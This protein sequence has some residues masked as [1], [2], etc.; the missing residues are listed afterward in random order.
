MYTHSSNP[1]VT[2]LTRLKKEL[3]KYADKKKALILERFF[4]TGP[5]E[6]GEGDLF[7]GV[8]VP[9]IRAVAK[10]YL[11][12][13]RKEIA[14]LLGSSIHEERLLALLILV[15]QFERAD[16]RDREKMF[17]FYL[18]HTRSIN[19]WDLVDLTSHRIVGNFLADKKRAL[20]YGL[21][22]SPSLWERRI[23]IVATFHFI[24]RGQFKDTLRI[25][26]LLLRD[27]ED[28]MHKAVGWMLREVGKRDRKQ[29]ELFLSKYCAL[30]PRTMLRYSLEHFPEGKRAFYMTRQKGKL[31]S[32]FGA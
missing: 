30:M 8:R 4:K 3:R 7:I 29:L 22:R 14:M 18:N 19:N 25:A 13:S 9:F 23:A 10:K 16:V 20:L 31:D 2:S 5:G 27:R 32:R 24:R 26:H 21:A 28:L 12:L 1:R 17:R 11:T 6:Y 15:G